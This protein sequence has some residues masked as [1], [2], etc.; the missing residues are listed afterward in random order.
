MVLGRVKVAPAPAGS[1]SKRPRVTESSPNIEAAEL[2]YS[3]TEAGAEEKTPSSLEAA[4]IREV[5]DRTPVPGSVATNA[6]GA[7]IVDTSELKARIPGTPLLRGAT[8]EPIPSLP[9]DAVVPGSTSDEKIK[10]LELAATAVA[11]TGTSSDQR[12]EAAVVPGNSSDRLVAAPGVTT[13]DA[14]IPTVEPRIQTSSL[15]KTVEGAAARNAPRV[16][17]PTHETPRE[18]PAPAAPKS[19]PAPRPSQSR[20]FLIALVIALAMFGA[21]MFLLQSEGD[22]PGDSRSGAVRAST[23]QA[24]PAPSELRAPAAAVAEPPIASAE[25]TSPSPSDNGAAATAEKAAATTD[26]VATAPSASSGLTQTSG[27]D[28]PLPAGAVITPGQG[29]LDIETGAREAIFVDGVELGRG[30]FL[31]LTLTPGVHEVRLRAHGEERIRFVLIRSTR[32]TR[33]PLSSAWAH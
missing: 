4:L 33:L 23:A 31:R 13:S 14:R 16:E 20:A 30:P 21:L 26:N 11:F 18:G 15:A 12:I 10:T 32:R 19:D 8:P 7:S 3:W 25:T 5:S 9:P 22:K 17:W 28:L 24:A 2:T 1:E 6:G 27:E 29:L